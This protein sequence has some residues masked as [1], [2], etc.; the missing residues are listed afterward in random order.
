MKQFILIGALLISIH[1]SVHGQSIFNYDSTGTQLQKLASRIQEDTILRNRLNADSIFTRALVQTLKSPYSFKYNFDSLT[2]IKHITSPDGR[3]KFFSWQVDLGDGTYRQR[4]AMQLP[5]QEGQLKLLP[6]FDNS[7]FVQNNT[8]G[9]YDR[10][11]WIGAIYYDIIPLQYNGT[12]IYTLLGFDENNT[13]VSKK[14][15]EVL[16]FENEEPILGG[17]FF[18]FPSDPTYPVGTIDRFIYNF[19]KG[20][21]AIIKYDKLQNRIMISELASTDNDLKKQETLVP[22]GNFKYFAWIN[23]KWELSLKEENSNKKK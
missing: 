12:S 4:G 21:N 19:K 16:R 23:N 9:V 1:C 18:K 6:F 7:D 20:S 2:A 15:I 17:D 10:K 8:L 13:S 5:T 14:I 22:S 3:F 11:K